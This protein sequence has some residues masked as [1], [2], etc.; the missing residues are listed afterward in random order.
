MEDDKLSA[1][2]TGL[3]WATRLTLGCLLTPVILGLLVIIGGVVWYRSFVA[4]GQRAVQAE[5]AKIRAS[6][7]PLTS[8]ELNASY[9]PHPDREDVTTELLAAIASLERPEIKAQAKVLPILDN[10][11]E[12]P[13][14]GQS[15]AQLA[16]VE[17]YLTAAADV[18]KFFESLPA[19]NPTAR[20]PVDLTAAIA[21]RLDH[22][23]TIRSAARLNSLQFHADLHRTNFDQAAERPLQSFALAQCLEAEPT[24]LSQ[25][26]RIAII[27]MA[28]KDTEE[29][30]RHT[31]PTDDQLLS[32]QLAARKVDMLS[33]LKTAIEGERAFG[34]TVSVCPLSMLKGGKFTADEINE[35]A[36]SMPNRPA[37][38]ALILSW[39]RRYL[40]GA[41]DSVPA[42]MKVADE[43]ELE[44]KELEKSPL[45]I[46]Y[47]QSL[48]LLPALKAAFI[49]VART[50]AQCKS[51]DAT[52]AAHRYRQ[53][54]G[55]W[56]TK[57][58]ELVPK[59]LSAIPLDPFN[60][61]PLLVSQSNSEFKVYSVGEN[62]IDDGGKWS[63]TDRSDYGFIATWHNQASENKE[64]Q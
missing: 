43:I 55:N 36:K 38:V 33:G 21:A 49:A 16:E 14:P 29:L 11:P 20:F 44:V 59:Y 50:E 61:Q 45:K 2:T 4:E 51:L 60:G 28:V 64:P 40:E 34:Y 41:N 8:V 53:A 24:T 10:G 25:L 7:S 62:Q 27:G 52:L 35:F 22:V 56:P 5:V 46:M 6:G 17:A 23:S 48:L 37:D 26:I 12:P 47:V 3:S 57:L 54:N 30:L 58:E 13:T 32:L 9:Q 39:Y 63:K 18:G 42:G 31:S 1:S 19:R 15:W